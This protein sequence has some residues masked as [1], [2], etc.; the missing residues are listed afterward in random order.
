MFWG[1]KNMGLGHL[2][3][4]VIANFIILSSLLG[5][6]GGGASDNGMKPTVYYKPTVS[7]ALH[8]TCSETL[9]IYSVDEKPLAE[10]CTK[11]YRNCLMQGSCF[12]RGQEGQVY[13]VNFHSMKNGVARF[14]EVNLDKCPFGYG[15][16]SICLDPYF[17][18]AADLNYH[19]PGDV[20]FVPRAVGVK[21]PFG[22]THDG[23]FIVRDSGGSIIG[24]RRFDF[25]T[26]FD[27]NISS[28]NVFAPIGF[29]DPKNRFEFRK[30]EG[31]EAE[32]IRFDRGYPHIKKAIF[33]SGRS[34]YKT[35]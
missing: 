21:T 30:V 8:Q 7:L 10:L 13:S 20:I 18:V 23:Y 9:H 27:S 3:T 32:R 16:N 28:S 29:G 24:D 26:G 22:E 14:V 2:L 34:Y 4:K 25:F 17:S 19:R 6:A 35:L 1:M 5:C 15:V 11:D 12:I 31:A 33:D